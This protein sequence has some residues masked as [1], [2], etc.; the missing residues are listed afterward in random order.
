MGERE[1]FLPFKDFPW[2][3]EAPIGKLLN[4]KLPR[5]GHLY[6]PDLDVDLAV[7]SIDHPQRYPLISKARPHKAREQ[8]APYKKRAVRR[9]AKRR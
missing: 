8:K 3:K 2:F 7:E 5:E 6:W 9:Q 1:L 4:V